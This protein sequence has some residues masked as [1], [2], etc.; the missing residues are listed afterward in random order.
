MN[1]AAN[2][3]HTTR[4][5]SAALE[6]MPHIFAVLWSSAAV[7]VMSSCE[8]S[9]GTTHDTLPSVTVPVADVT[10]PGRCACTVTCTAS[11]GPAVEAT[12]CSAYGTAPT[13]ARTSG[14]ANA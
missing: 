11:L 4:P 8:P 3:H 1:A 14:S 10:F 2:T 12:T 13:A 7:V 5:M 9:S 6:A